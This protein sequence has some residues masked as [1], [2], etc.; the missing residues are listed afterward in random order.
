MKNLFLS[1]LALLAIIGCDTKTT[2]LANKTKSSKYAGKPYR[3]TVKALSEQKIPGKL[4]CEFYDVGGEGVAYHDVDNKNS[5]SGDLNK[6]AGYYA[7]F[8]KDEAVDISF[9]KYHDS[10]D[11][12]IYN[13]VQP[14]IDQL[15]LGWTESGEWIAYTVDVLETG[16]YK[17]GAMYTSNRGGSVRFVVENA[18][19]SALM[20]IPSTFNEKEPIAWRNWHHWNYVDSLAVIHLKKGKRILKLEIAKQGNF[21]FD[22]FNF[23]KVKGK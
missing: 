19:A 21:N 6:G 2:T 8:R 15:Y 1:L 3:D 23:V 5:G 11:N 13:I 17:I 4:E 16:N 10:I 9:T 12:S 20:E 22:Y 14:K 7:Q 18:D